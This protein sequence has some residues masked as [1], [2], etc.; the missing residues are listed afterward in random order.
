MGNRFNHLRAM[1]KAVLPGIV[2]GLI[3]CFLPDM[4]ALHAQS[5]EPALFEEAEKLF[6]E[7]NYY[8]AAQAYEKYLTGDKDKKRI[9]SSPFAVRKKGGAQSVDGSVARQGAVY[10]LAESYRLH[11]D[12]KQAEKWYKEAASYSLSSYPASQYWYGVTLRTNQKY[13]EAVKVITEFR[14]SRKEKD[15][16]TV[17]ADRELE[18][19]RY[20]RAQAETSKKMATVTRKPNAANTSAYSFA[21]STAKEA[22]F[23]AMFVDS[24]KMY[25]GY[26]AYSAR[27]Y[28]APDSGNIRETAKLV[29]IPEEPGYNN[30]L[31][32]V[33]ND[34]QQLFFTRWQKND[35]VITAA[36]Y[37]SRKNA[38]GTW[39][40]ARKLSSPVNL[41]GSNSTQPFI[42]P[43]GQYLLFSSDRKGGFGK[44][45][46]WFA[47]LNADREAVSAQNMGIFIN[48]PND[49]ATPW[50]H[51]ATNSL[52]F[53]SNGH[54][55]MGGFDIYASKGDIETAK[56][57]AP[58]NPGD[59]INSTKDD[60][61]YVGTD[62]VN[63][64]NTGWL[65][66]DR[67][68]DCCLDLFAVVSDNVQYISGKVI[69]KKNGEP[70]KGVSL[71]IRDPK[72]NDSTMLAVETDSLGFYQFELRNTS[73]YS[74]VAQ[75]PTYNND[76]SSYTVA[77]VTGRDSIKN[78]DLAL[79][80]DEIFDPDVGK[81]PD[82]SNE[83]YKP[84]K[85]KDPPERPPGAA[86]RPMIVARFEFDKSFLQKKYYHNLDTLIKIM[87]KDPSMIVEVGGHTD[88]F[89]TEEYNLQLAQ[90]RVDACISYLRDHG[91]SAERLIS[92][93]YGESTPAVR[94]IVDGSDNP[95]GRAMNR[96]VEF[97]VLQGAA[98]NIV[99]PVVAEGSNERQAGEK[100][101]TP[102]GT[103]TKS[104]RVARG[105]NTISEAFQPIVH[106]SFDKSVV[107][108]E[109]FNNLDR[110]AELMKQDPS[111]KVE[112]NGYT[113]AKGSAAY[114][115]KLAQE[116]VDA[117]IVY[118][119]QQGI[120]RTRLSGVALGECCPLEA[121]TINGRDN[122]D[123]RFMNRR[124]EF[125]FIR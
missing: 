124:V 104:G 95:E 86:N 92:K 7:K 108:N 97:R 78:K 54:V 10:R 103:A 85:G 9:S 46:L 57:E 64:W 16:W 39:S 65:S 63:L 14:E 36:I 94:E 83:I 82:P 93:S 45:D 112:V 115:L 76:T 12:Y 61:Y 66:S 19:L 31:P 71:F 116:R 48:T 123:G 109:Y 84:D 56:W 25:K 121:E 88:A 80:S 99:V 125:K 111:M 35:G 105:R 110:L 51:P 69:D 90:D 70:L 30:G 120:S 96:R 49:E 102:D 37:T 68:T 60:Q 2:C 47:K 26:P 3:S 117:V 43:D 29:D 72:K 62:D 106:F 107:D 59:P 100:H 122:P 67:E 41:E 33:S 20:I 114:N 21:T 119:E 89:G 101:Y 28:S 8:E 32:S 74:I 118:L 6:N 15:E 50:Y 91:I 113:D 75:K 77:I 24:S 40:A 1:R 58:V 13:D 81:P 18:N 38:D 79:S 11:N 53:S 98:S 34:G 27:L 55:G 42:T 4:G 5:N 44:Y 23:T 73:R 22:F 17:A 87:E 52:V